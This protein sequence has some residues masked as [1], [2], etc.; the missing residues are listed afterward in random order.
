MKKLIFVLAAVY[1]F[2]L[3]C[4]KKED[5]LPNISPTEVNNTLCAGTWK[6]T[7]YWDFDQ[8]QTSSF[9]GYSFLFAGENK[10]TASKPGLTLSGTWTTGKDDSI[11]KLF[12]AFPGPIKFAEISED[13]IVTEMTDTR[14]ELQDESDGIG[15]TDWL[16]FEK[17]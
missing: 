15:E 11:I 13:W 1:I 10:L 12:L 5:P 7:Y 8:E 16:T 14:I 4:H 17:N 9:S 3:A 2:L 6:I